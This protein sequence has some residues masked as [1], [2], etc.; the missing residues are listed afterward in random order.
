MAVTVPKLRIPK[1]SGFTRYSWPPAQE[2]VNFGDTL[3]F[4]E[5]NRSPAEDE[6][7]SDIVGPYPNSSTS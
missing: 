1:Y 6:K 3:V 5:S 4:V 2:I 7:G